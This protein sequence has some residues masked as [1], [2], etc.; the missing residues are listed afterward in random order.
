MAAP[1]PNREDEIGRLDAREL[2]PDDITE[3]RA[4]V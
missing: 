4:H 1:H 3:H 2:G